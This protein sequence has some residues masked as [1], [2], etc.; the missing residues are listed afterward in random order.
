MSDATTG[1]LVQAYYD[2]WKDGIE[3]FNEPRLRDILAPDLHFEGPIAG[4][5][6]SVE[7]FLLGLEDFV[8]SMK[9]YEPV[10]QVCSGAE[11]AVLYDCALGPSKGTL[12]FA[13]FFRVRDGR[14]QELRLL[15]DAAEFKRL[16]AP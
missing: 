9:A 16:I 13:E 4:K 6:D 14:I 10:Q 5:R 7:P 8:R 2:S 3:S 15:Y 12:R 1:E 11:A